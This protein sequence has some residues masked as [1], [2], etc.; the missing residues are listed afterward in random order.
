M[1]LVGIRREWRRRRYN[2]F[3]DGVVDPVELDTDMTGIGEGSGN[4]IELVTCQR[5][6]Q[7]GNLPGIF[8]RCGEPVVAALAS[9]PLPR[10][11]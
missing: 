6:L 11:E 4:M 5:Q 9:N 7:P 2:G 10:M 3:R 1:D 8:T